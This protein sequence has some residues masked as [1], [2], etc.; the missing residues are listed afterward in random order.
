ML[1]SAATTILVVVLGL[2]VAYLVAMR[3]FPGKRLVEVLVELPIVLP[4]TVAGVGLL[5]AFGRTGL[6][7]GVLRAFGLSLPFTTLAVIVA[8]LFVATPFFITAVSAG[9]R[10]VEPKYRDVAVTLRASPLYVFRRVLLPMALPSIVAG[11]AMAWARALGEFGA[12]ITFAG[13]LMG[14]TQTMPL[15]VYS[16]LQSDLDSAVAIAV[17]LIVFSFAILVGLRFAPWGA[18]IGGTGARPRRR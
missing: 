3:E 8:Q 7:G 1:T 15:A 2:P 13:N 12:T 17:V 16:A 9:L 5:L 4:P 10:E 6:A 18:A 11:A 14:R